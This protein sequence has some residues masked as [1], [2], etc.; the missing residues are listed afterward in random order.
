LLTPQKIMFAK[1]LLFV[2]RSKDWKALEYANAFASV[3]LQTFQSIAFF[4]F[5]FIK[6][7]FGRQRWTWHKT[8]RREEQ[9]DISSSVSKMEISIS[10]F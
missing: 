5:S 2:G 10:I 4:E 8:S 1:M 6:P 3:F 9:S 7:G